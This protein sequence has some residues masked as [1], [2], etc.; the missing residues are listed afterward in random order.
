MTEGTLAFWEQGMLI[1]SLLVCEMALVVDAQ[2]LLSA[3]VSDVP[4]QLLL[5]TSY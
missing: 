1:C 5:G 3:S 4:S 2:W